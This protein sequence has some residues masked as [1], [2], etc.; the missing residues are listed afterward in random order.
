MFVKNNNIH[1]VGAI[2]NGTI[3]QATYWINGAATRISAL[4]SEAGDITVNENGV[5][6]IF[7]ENEISGPYGGFPL[8]LK[9]WNEGVIRTISNQRADQGNIL[10]K[11]TDVYIS[12]SERTDGSSS[13]F[14]ACYWKNGVKT[15]FPGVTTNTCANIKM[16]SNGDLFVASKLVYSGVAPLTYWQN[17]IK[18]TIGRSNESFIAFDIN[19]K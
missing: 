1:V 18:K 12:G 6:L 19:K 3:F 16:G 17:N 14:A 15:V 7:N 2:S 10:V 11:G 9:Y 5:H 8:V 13:I 4:D